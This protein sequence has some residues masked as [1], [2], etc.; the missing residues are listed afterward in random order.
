MSSK[1]CE[2]GSLGRA[3]FNRGCNTYYCSYPGIEVS[4]LLISS[5]HLL[6]CVKVSIKLSNRKDKHAA[7]HDDV[8]NVLIRRSAVHAYPVVISCVK[9]YPV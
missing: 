6:P 4:L 1:N 9:V 8:T 5:I 2:F 7:S 3:S